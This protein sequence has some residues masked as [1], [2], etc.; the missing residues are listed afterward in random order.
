MGL[1]KS[2]EE[3]EMEQRL[4]IKKTMSNIG[5]YITGLENQKEKYIDA[6]KKAKLKVYTTQYNLAL[7][8]LKT[9][10]A[11]QKKAEEMLLNFELTSQMRDLT[12][13]TST[14]LGGMSVI[15]K[16][17][18]KITDNMDFVKVQKEFEKA[19]MGVEST[20]ENLDV[21][22]DTS[23]TSFESIAN[24]SSKVA[25]EE[26]E[27]LIDSDLADDEKQLDS[28]L[29]AKMAEIKKSLKDI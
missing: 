20:T 29:A 14:F 4:L 26:I 27:R 3:K 24:T 9:A 18:A 22:L 19:M 25:N 5:K 11:Q 2:K 7:S 23:N 21:L 15:S 8:G 16:E 1:F 13:M 12:K 10:M 28:D 6:A 17:M